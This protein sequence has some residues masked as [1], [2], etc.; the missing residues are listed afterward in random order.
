M[1]ERQHLIDG[2]CAL[3]KGIVERHP[4]ESELEI[5]SL[6]ADMVAKGLVPVTYYVEIP[7]EVTGHKPHCQ[8]AHR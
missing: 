3:C 4:I 6:R 7:K 8:K 2:V 5:P 1:S